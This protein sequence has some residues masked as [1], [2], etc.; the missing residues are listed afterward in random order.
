MLRPLSDGAPGKFDASSENDNGPWLPNDN[1]KLMLFTASGCG[2]GIGLL[3]QKG[4]TL[5][6]PH[7]KAAWSRETT[8][9]P[10]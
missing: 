6:G 8:R 1:N 7:I 2:S 9:T 3:Q 10:Y 4:S 5:R